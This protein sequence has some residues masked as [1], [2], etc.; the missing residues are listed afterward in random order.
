MT[1]LHHLVGLQQIC[2]A[3]FV[4][5]FELRAL[6]SKLILEL[7]FHVFP[8]YIGRRS[9]WAHCWRACCWPGCFLNHAEVSCAVAEEQVRVAVCMMSFR[10]Y[11]YMT[12]LKCALIGIFGCTYDTL[13]LCGLSYLD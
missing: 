13:V 6:E 3:D 11:H 5:L 4:V 1:D 10:S 2:F 8:C 9:H 12:V 7:L